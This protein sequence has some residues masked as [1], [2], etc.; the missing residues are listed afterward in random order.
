MLLALLIPLPALSWPRTDPRYSFTLLFAGGL[1]F[2]YSLAQGFILGLHGWGW[3]FLRDIFGPTVQ[4]QM[5]L[6]Y[7]AL[8]VC[9]GFLFLFTQGLAA[10]G[11]I[12]GDV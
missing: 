4:T 6:G 10:R 8:L 7:G 3:D 9:G 11:A 1:G 5:G 2:F 12:K